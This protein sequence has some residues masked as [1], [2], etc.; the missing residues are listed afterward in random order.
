MES[1]HLAWL[2]GNIIQLKILED[3]AHYVGFLLTPAE[4]LFAPCAKKRAFYA[5]LA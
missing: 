2:A 1:G 5:V 3:K 4:A